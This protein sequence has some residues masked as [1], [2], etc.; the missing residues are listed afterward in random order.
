MENR[1]P[2]QER[3]EE[4][5]QTIIAAAAAELVEN[6]LQSV[7][8]RR[9]AEL[10]NSS[11]R[12]TTYYF[13]SVKA[14]RLEAMKVLFGFGH[15]ARA[16]RIAELRTSHSTP[17][18]K[19]LLLATYGEFENPR[20]ILKFQ[21]N[22]ALASLDETYTDLITQTAQVVEDQVQEI[23]EIYGCDLP[24]ARVISTIDGRLLEW[25]QKQGKTNFEENIK[26]DL[27]I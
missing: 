2:R 16:A 26:N 23:L 14:L 9:V 11:L 24:A 1:Q 4:T 6:G 7:T 27:G 22:I 25:A 21:S 20:D 18:V 17:L 3:S 19:E 8:H 10:A 15:R 12:S 5:L 13:K